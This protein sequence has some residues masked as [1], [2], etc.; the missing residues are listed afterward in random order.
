MLKNFLQRRVQDLILSL[1]TK[2]SKADIIFSVTVTLIYAAIALPVG[3][4]TGFLKIHVL[5]MSTLTMVT[6]P[7]SLLVMPSLLE[8]L[9]FRALMLPHKTR[10]N[11][12]QKKVFLSLFSI[13]AFIAWH[14]LNAMTMNAAAYPIFTDPVFLLLA[15]LMA[16]AC[17]IA[18]LK[19]GSVWI[20]VSI[21]WITVL[22]WLFFLGGRNIVLD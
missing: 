10:K 19:S 2:P 16:C 13:F 18:Y 14:P 11:T 22:V 3:L 1:I 9:F 5:Q 7:V 4:F 20:P 21:H 12:V 8:E 15:A 17:T 6:L